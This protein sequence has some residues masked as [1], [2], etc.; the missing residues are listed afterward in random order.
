MQAHSPPHSIGLS[1]DHV[2]LGQRL[3]HAYLRYHLS[4]VLDFLL[5]SP[6]HHSGRKITTRISRLSLN[7]WRSLPGPSQSFVRQFSPSRSF[8]HSFNCPYSDKPLQPHRS[9]VQTLF[10]IEGSCGEDC[11]VAES[12]SGSIEVV[13][14][15]EVVR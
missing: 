14:T 9:H 1:E 13:E 10:Q 3:N 8:R 15:A 5:F 11:E 12:F 2:S 4:R 7:F 6:P